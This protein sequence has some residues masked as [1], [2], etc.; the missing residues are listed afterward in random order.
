MNSTVDYKYWLA[1]KKYYFSWYIPLIT[2]FGFT[3]N[4]F[5]VFILI[6]KFNNLPSLCFWIICTCGGN[7]SVIMVQGPFLFI[8]LSIGTH[9]V[10]GVDIRA[11]N[12][13]SCQFF[14]F[15]K[16]IS[17]AWTNCSLAIL[18]VMR[19]IILVKRLNDIEN[20][21]NNIVIFLAISLTLTSYALFWP[22]IYHVKRIENVNVCQPVDATMSI[23]EACMKFAFHSC[24]IAIIITGTTCYLIHYSFEMFKFVKRVSKRKFPTTS[25]ARS[26]K[27]ISKLRINRLMILV[28]TINIAWLLC[29]IPYMSY[30]FIYHLKT[31]S[32]SL[33]IYPG[34]YLLYYGIAVLSYSNYCISWI[35]YHFLNEPLKQEVKYALLSYLDRL[36][37]I[38]ARCFCSYVASQ[39]YRYSEG[40]VQFG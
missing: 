35:F 8:F 40:T 10:S 22:L 36:E 20:Q 21:E 5:T 15:L 34:D 17:Y 32:I 23:V 9:K 18:C 24:L 19:V 39:T 37:Y 14:V 27:F 30:N 2:I 12:T 16:E 4:S 31:N 38:L 25:V 13:P 29:N 1:T 33:I 7:I 26:L 6:K 28:V 3:G 11:L